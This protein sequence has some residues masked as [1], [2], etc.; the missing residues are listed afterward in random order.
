MEGWGENAGLR[1]VG[2]AERHP[3]MYTYVNMSAGQAIK[4]MLCVGVCMHAHHMKR[5]S[6]S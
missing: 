3:Q 2:S 1:F 4:Y 5:V 6:V